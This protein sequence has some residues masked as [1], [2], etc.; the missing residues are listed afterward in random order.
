MFPLISVIVPIYN[1]ENY[2]DKCID[3][4]VNQTYK[5]LEIILVDDGSPDRCPSICDEWAE[6]DSRIKVIHKKNGGVSSARNAGINIA[7]GDYIG[8]VDGDDIIEN[9]TY[10]IMISKVVEENADICMCSFKYLNYQKNEFTKGTE[11]YAEEKTFSPDETC[12]E[13][14]ETFNGH[15]V[16]LCNKIIDRRLFEGL[17]FPVGRVFEDWTL[18]PMLYAKCKKI[19]YIPDKLYIYVIHDNSIM[20]TESVKRYYD[21]VCADYDHYNYFKGIDNLNYNSNI[22]FL[23]WNDFMKICKIYRHSKENLFMIKDAYRKSKAV[24]S[25]L[26]GSLCYYLRGILPILYKIRRRSAV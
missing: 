8:F 20:R 2:L 6:K 21:C 23:I 25:N 13:F 16:S 18:A 17:E 9:D 14:F 19:V 3:S 22:E 10:S 5:N 26:K 7:K 15:L 12:K 4:I 24:C 11:Y 1:V